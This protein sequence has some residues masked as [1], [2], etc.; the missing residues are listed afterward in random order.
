[1]RDGDS[2][3]IQTLCRGS[4]KEEVGQGRRCREGFIFN[5]GFSRQDGRG[6]SYGRVGTQENVLQTTFIDTCG[7]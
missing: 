1:M 6:R 4:E 7:Y 5:Q 3:Q 2:R